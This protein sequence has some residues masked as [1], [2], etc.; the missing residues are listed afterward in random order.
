MQTKNQEVGIWDWNLDDLDQIPIPI[1]KISFRDTETGFWI[2]IT[3]YGIR[4]WELGSEIQI[5]N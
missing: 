2:K 3:D 5:L 1:A 4:Y